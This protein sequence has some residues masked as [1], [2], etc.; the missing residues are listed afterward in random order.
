MAFG[1]GFLPRPGSRNRSG[2]TRA[3]AP[4]D[5]TGGTPPVLP[6]AIIEAP[7][8]VADPA[9]LEM[10]PANQARVLVDTQPWRYTDARTWQVPRWAEPPHVPDRPFDGSDAWITD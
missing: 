8:S 6:W 3:L 1:Y 10:L 2:V 4:A 9:L 7:V 5:R